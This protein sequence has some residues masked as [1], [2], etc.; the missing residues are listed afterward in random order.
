M[1][2]MASV[3]DKRED[4]GTKTKAEKHI[5]RHFQSK[6]DKLGMAANQEGRRQQLPYREGF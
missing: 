4:T 2:N 6:M 1:N 3:Q 5:C